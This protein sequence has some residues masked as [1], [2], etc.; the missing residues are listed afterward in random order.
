MSINIITISLNVLCLLYS[1]LN[2]FPVIVDFS[3]VLKFQCTFIM[4]EK[5]NL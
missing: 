1:S 4:R 5:T 2:I 3:K